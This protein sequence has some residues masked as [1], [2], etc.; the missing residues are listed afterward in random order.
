M[1][2][3]TTIIAA[4]AAV[5]LTGACNKA[6]VEHEGSA[7]TL[8]YTVSLAEAATKAIGDGTTVDTMVYAIFDENGNQVK[9][10]PVT[11]N[12]NSFSFSPALY[13]GQTYTIALFAYKKGPYKESAY[14][15]DD[16]KAITRTQ[17]GEAADAFSYTETIKITDNGKLSINGET[18]V[19]NE[20]RYVKLTRL[21]AQLAIGT[22]DNDFENFRVTSVE[23]TVKGYDVASYN[24]KEKKCT[25]ATVSSDLTYELNA[26]DFTSN[27]PF[28][29]G[30]N[31]YR[32]VSVNYLFPTEGVSTEV[33]KTVVI[34]LKKG[35]NVVRTIE[36]PN[37]PL[38]ANKKTQIYGNLVKGDIEF[39]VTV[40]AG[41]DAWD[42]ED[43]G[44][45][46]IK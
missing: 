21:V 37:V 11:K 16:I 29:V 17:N 5:L 44:K 22:E 15:V 10:E 2:K 30:S 20:P 28:M 14:N 18:P 26:S 1:K 12:G 40:S 24:A 4:M 9:S 34:T 27:D 42:P 35:S 19:A 23:V 36:L 45:V 43:K 39:N 41:F 33:L 31:A 25:P 6:E 3:L 13:Y 8:D 32:Y 7:V 46:E 38:V